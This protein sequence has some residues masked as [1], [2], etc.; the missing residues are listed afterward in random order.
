[1]GKYA[2]WAVKLAN[3]KFANDTQ[4]AVGPALF[5]TRREARDW[6]YTPGTTEKG[7]PVKVTVTVRQE[8]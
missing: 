7:T 6:W 8:K 2:G 1:M 5:A 3:G 4:G